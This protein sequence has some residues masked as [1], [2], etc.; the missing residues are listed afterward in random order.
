[1]S[2]KYK[3]TR[4]IQVIR[5]EQGSLFGVQDGFED[6]TAVEQEYSIDSVMVQYGIVVILA[7]IQGLQ[8]QEGVQQRVQENLEEFVWGEACKGVEY[9]VDVGVV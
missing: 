9:M 5:R 3:K 1:M 4:K 7:Q 6:V 8:V 2:E